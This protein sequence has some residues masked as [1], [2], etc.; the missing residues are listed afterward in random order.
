MFDLRGFSIFKNALNQDELAQINGWIDARADELGSAEPGLHIDGLPIQSY[1]SSG[2]RTDPA[3]GRS[4]DDGINVQHVFEVEGW[5]EGLID[6]PS[7]FGR[8]EHYLGSFTPFIH[9]LFINIRGPGGFIGC[10]SGGPRFDED[11]HILASRWGAAVYKDEDTDHDE[12]FGQGSHRGHKVA[13]G[14]PYLSMIVA[15]EDIGPGVKYRVI[16][17][18]CC[19]SR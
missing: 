17:F 4:I 16:H 5:G 9:E 15:L 3:S 6:H 11:G 19:P 14:V 18:V 7:W 10:H 8:V 2:T 13:W 12:Y 1:Y